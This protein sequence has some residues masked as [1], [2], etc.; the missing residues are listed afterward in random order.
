VSE[1]SRVI[2]AQAAQR[3]NDL[4][5]AA[6]ESTSG[7]RAQLAGMHL[8]EALA[9]LKLPATD[10]EQQQPAAEQL[11]AYAITAD[12]CTFVRGLTYPTF[13]FV[14]SFI[15]LLLYA[16]AGRQNPRLA[17]FTTA[18]SGDHGLGALLQG[19]SARRIGRIGRI[20]AAYQWPG[21][22]R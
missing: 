16:F 1:Q 15:S 9:N 5:K 18:W 21:G 3:A 11:E 7:A 4:S 19:L 14:L 13:R 10:G 12:F 22:W 2:A 8:P 20:P 6:A 17:K